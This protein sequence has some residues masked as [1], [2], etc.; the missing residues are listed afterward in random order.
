MYLSARSA[1]VRSI[2]GDSLA[3]L[4]ET[5]AAT[6]ASGQHVKSEMAQVDDDINNLPSFSDDE[7]VTGAS[8]VAV[9]AEPV[10]SAESPRSCSQERSGTADLDEPSPDSPAQPAL[11]AEAEAPQ[12]TDAAGAPC[13]PRE[14]IFD[15]K[16][17][18]ELIAQGCALMC[19]ALCFTVFPCCLLLVYPIV[20]PYDSIR[21]SVRPMKFKHAQSKMSACI[22]QSTALHIN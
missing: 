3:D 17:A 13:V 10:P 1:R 15:R 6:A 2:A 7:A 9:K 11:S 22:Q 5:G 16:L 21:P 19:F 20:R 18:A 8:A 12:H 14:R 4:A